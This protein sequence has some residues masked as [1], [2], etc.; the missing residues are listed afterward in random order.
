MKKIDSHGCLHVTKYRKRHSDTCN[1]SF[2]LLIVTHSFLEFDG[3]FNK[4]IS[5]LKSTRSPVALMMRGTTPKELQGENGSQLVA[6][7]KC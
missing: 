5:I 3:S 2:S 6:G 4:A 7:M 1:I